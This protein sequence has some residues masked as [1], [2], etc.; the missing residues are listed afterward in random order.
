MEPEFGL[1]GWP[2]LESL[3]TMGAP[4]VEVVQPY[5]LEK[6]TPYPVVNLF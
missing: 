1:T 4:A 3:W 2:V 5:L 6:L